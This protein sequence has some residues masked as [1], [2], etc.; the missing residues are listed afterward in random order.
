ML[1]QYDLPQ[2]T[3]TLAT[4]PQWK[5]FSPYLIASNSNGTQSVFAAPVNDV[6]LSV[7]NNPSFVSMPDLSLTFY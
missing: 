5:Q 1:N 6:L 3:L 2:K 7:S 4:F